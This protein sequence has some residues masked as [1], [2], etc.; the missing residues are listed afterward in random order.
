MGFIPLIFFSSAFI[1]LWAIVNYNS[2]QKTN[3]E[4][5]I[6]VKNLANL[7][8]DKNRLLAEN[9]AEFKGTDPKLT[10]CFQKSSEISIP[11]RQSLSVFTQQIGESV[12]IKAE[13]A[14]IESASQDK[15]INPEVS[16]VIIQKNKE[17]SSAVFALKNKI[18]NYNLLVGKPPSK[19]IANLFKFKPTAI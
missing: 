6:M 14:L 19:F 12:N 10:H 3:A 8:K 4:I 17:I 13:N 9:A 16:E 5:D 7:V 11:D 2:L 15:Q 1:F 18:K